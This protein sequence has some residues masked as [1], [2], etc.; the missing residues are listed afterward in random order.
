MGTEELGAVL[1]ERRAS[2]GL[3]QQALADRAG[4][5]RNFVAQVERGESSPTVS[6]LTRL[7]VALATTV[8][9]LLGEETHA[10]EPGDAVAVPLR[11]Q[12]GETPPLPAA[13]RIWFC[14]L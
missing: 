10:P 3:S 13:T 11:S 8:G 4:L 9:E 2:Q 14:A 6:T 12:V 1:R 5:S 7:A